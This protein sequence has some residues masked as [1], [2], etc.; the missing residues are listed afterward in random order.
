VLLLVVTSF[1]TIALLYFQLARE[2]HKWWWIS[3]INGGSTGIFILVYSWFWYFKRSEMEGVLQGSFFF[4]YMAVISYAFFLLL[5][6]CSFLSS[7][8]FVRGI[9]GRLKIDESNSVNFFQKF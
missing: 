2:D 3:F 6:S 4:T 9:Y 1:I 7:M 8:A 5:G